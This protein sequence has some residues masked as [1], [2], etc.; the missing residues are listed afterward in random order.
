M[1]EMET[2]DNAV[3]RSNGWDRTGSWS[4]GF[5]LDRSRDRV[6]LDEFTPE[7]VEEI[8]AELDE[9]RASITRIGRFREIS[10]VLARHGLLYLL[11]DSSLAGA[12][13]AG[14]RP[15]EGRADSLEKIGVR[16][17]LAF[18]ELGPTFI[19][20]GQVLV[21]RQEILPEQITTELSKLLDYIPPMPFPYLASVIE[22]ELPEGLGTFRYIDHENPIGS[23][24]L[25]QVYRAELRDGTPVAVKV[26]RP[27]VRELFNTD[28][29]VIRFLAKRLHKLLPAPVALSLDLPGL[30]GEYYSSSMEE[31]DMTA[32][33]EAMGRARRI[34]EEH[35]FETVRVPDVHLYTRSVLVMEFVDG[36]DLTEFPVDFLTFEERLQR[37]TDLAH[38]YVYAFLSGEYHAD[39]HA[40]N[41]LIDR[42]TKDAVVVDWGMIGRMDAVH[43]EAIFRFLM[44]IRLNQ[45]SDAAEICAEIIEPTKYT[46]LSKLKDQWRGM[47]M[48]YVDSPQSSN[49]NWGNLL[50]SSIRI[51]MQN[52]CRIPT[53][54]ALWTKGF[55]AAEGTARWLCP[56]VSYHALVE[57]ADVQI[58]RSILMRRFNYRANASL[59]GEL[60]ELVSTFPR[61]MNQIF[62]R[63]AWNDLSIKQEYRISED[64]IRDLRKI[65]RDIKKGMNRLAISTIASPLLYLGARELLRTRRR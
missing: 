8:E 48:R 53:G 42:H 29:T 31:L 51:G 40:S 34:L 36:W 43:T 2:Q 13:G 25:A 28:I 21:T 20:L 47:Y 46:N 56:E 24:S 65:S 19:K 6:T 26:I 41:I 54:L 39:P 9:V 7:L 49:Y 10:R 12:F 33:A 27:G 4:S 55:T 23:A 18:Q 15:V 37:M 60:G 30:V 1:P 32:E 59:V 16:L 3:F 17:R 11:R 22:R 14:K 58:M 62:K 35:Q 52:H 50:L 38:Y 57:S 5:K 64:S 45:C 63:L 44:H 61:R